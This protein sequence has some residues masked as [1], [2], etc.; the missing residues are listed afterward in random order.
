MLISHILKP[1]AVSALVCCALAVVGAG[2]VH[3]A[4]TKAKAVIMAWI[5]AVASGEKKIIAAVLAPEFQILRADGVG[6]DKAAYVAGGAAK[7]TRILDIS[8]VIATRQDNL[9]VTR[10]ML[11]VTET[12]KGHKVQ[13][14]APR[15]T[16][17][18][19]AGAHWLVVAH[20]NFARIKN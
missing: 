12:I 14:K 4:D 17:F 13:K 16:V 7:I 2:S 8:D 3:A 9:L 1:F 10:Y 18:R 20:A 15:L 11:G 19:R 6:H 5:Q